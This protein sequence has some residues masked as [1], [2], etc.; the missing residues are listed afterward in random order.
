MPCCCCCSLAV[1]ARKSLRSTSLTMS[2]T[3]AWSPAGIWPH[4]G[5]WSSSSATPGQLRQACDSAYMRSSGF[6]AAIAP[7]SSLFPPARLSKFHAGPSIAR[8]TNPCLQHAQNVHRLTTT[9]A[10]AVAPQPAAAAALTA[11]DLQHR[12]P[13]RAPVAQL[14]VQRQRRAGSRAEP[15]AALALLLQLPGGPARVLR[16]EAEVGGFGGACGYCCCGAVHVVVVHA[17][18]DL[19]PETQGLNMTSCG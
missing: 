3:R 9:A 15:H 17:L 11:H 10:A 1:A 18:R 8:C 14:R 13:H 19:Q 6:P 2:D 5:T 16:K 12:M 7:C 4:T